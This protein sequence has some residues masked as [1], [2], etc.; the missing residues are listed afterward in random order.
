MGSNERTKWWL[1]A[2][3]VVV[4]AGGL[5]LGAPI[6]VLY[7]ANLLLTYMVLAIGLDVLLGRAGQFAFAHIAFYGI[8]I[9]TT[10]LMTNHTDLPF[11]VGI[12]A[13][14]VIAGRSR[15]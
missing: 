4:A 7:I 9:Y 5:Y 14:G 2:L 8:G 1:A 10:A 11:F 13:A 15:C 12:A 6:Y 3:T